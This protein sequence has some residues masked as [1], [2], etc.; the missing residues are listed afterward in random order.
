MSTDPVSQK[1]VLPQS[2]RLRRFYKT[3]EVVSDEAGELFLIH[4][5][6]KPARTPGGE[7]ISVCHDALAL[8]IAAE[9]AAQGEEIAPASMPITRLVNTALDGVRDKADAVLVDIVK[10]AG[11]D[12]VCYRANEPQELV[13]RQAAAWDPVLAWARQTL[14]AEFVVANGIIFRAQSSVSL[15][16][17]TESLHDLA[18]DPLELAA[19]HTMTTIS[20]SALIALSMAMGHMT[21][22]HAFTAAN[23]DEDW[24][25]ERWGSDEEAET[26]RANRWRDFSAAARIFTT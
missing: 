3:V 1:P 22:E 7:K 17:F 18:C 20:G 23:I 13:E 24:N 4:L 5:D 12:L 9:W 21:V 15:A 19:L 14:G 6:G 11:S 25:R 16:A 10:Y 8:L 2:K 26:M